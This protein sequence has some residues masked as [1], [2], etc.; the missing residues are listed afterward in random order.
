MRYDIATPKNIILIVINVLIKTLKRIACLARGF[1]PIASTPR[2]EALAKNLKPKKKDER[3]IAPAT[4][5]LMTPSGELNASFNP[6][7]NALKILCVMLFVSCAKC[8]WSV[9]RIKLVLEG[10]LLA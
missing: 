5:Y 3:V 9:T 8:G 7:V 6:K 4:K 1:L 2:L 10:S